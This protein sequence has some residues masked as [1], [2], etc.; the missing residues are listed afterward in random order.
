MQKLNKLIMNEFEQELN[1][2]PYSTNWYTMRCSV[3]GICEKYMQK[4]E[5]K[6]THIYEKVIGN[7]TTRFVVFYIYGALYVW[8]DMVVDGKIECSQLDKPYN[9]FEAS[10]LYSTVVNASQI[11]SFLFQLIDRKEITQIS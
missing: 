7:N 6:W 8:A 11:S 5:C 3:A 9:D 2:C 4:S 10:V 1:N